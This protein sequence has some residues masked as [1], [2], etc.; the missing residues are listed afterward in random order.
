MGPG[1]AEVLEQIF[2]VLFKMSLE[3]SVFLRN[4][5][6]FAANEAIQDELARAY[7]DILVF[8][9]DATVR[10]AKATRGIC[11]LFDLSSQI[12]MKSATSVKEFDNLYRRRVDSFFHHRDQIS[13]VM[14]THELQ[15]SMDSLS[16]LAQ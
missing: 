14:W 12:L 6:L 11:P 9:I 13:N 10:Y 4:R 5:K 15:Q 2:G 1:S 8:V 16:V 7:A 3:L